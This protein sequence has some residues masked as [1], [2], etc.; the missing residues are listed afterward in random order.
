MQVYQERWYFRRLNI[1][2]G[3][4]CPCLWTPDLESE[5]SEQY[6]LWVL[7]PLPVRGAATIVPSPWGGGEENRRNTDSVVASGTFDIWYINPSFFLNLS[8]GVTIIIKELK[9]AHL[10]SVKLKIE[11]FQETDFIRDHLSVSNSFP[12]FRNQ[13]D[14]V[15][16]FLKVNGTCCLSLGPIQQEVKDK[17]EL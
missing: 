14:S 12:Q 17:T 10:L 2:R 15:L 3:C 7:L 1:I 9:T 13:K 4:R 5:M 16:Q 8:L 6:V 11:F